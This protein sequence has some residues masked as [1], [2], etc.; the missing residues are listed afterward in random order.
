LAACPG[1]WLNASSADWFEEYARLCF[2]EFGEEVKFWITFNEPKETSI[3][4][5]KIS[6]RGR[7]YMITS[8]RIYRSGT[9]RL[10][11]ISQKT[12]NPR[13]FVGGH[14]CQVSKNNLRKAEDDRRKKINCGFEDFSMLCK[15]LISNLVYLVI[16]IVFCLFQ[17][18][19]RFVYSYERKN[20]SPRKIILSRKTDF[21]QIWQGFQQTESEQSR[22]NRLL[23]FRYN[24]YM[25]TCDRII[26]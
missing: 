2:T 25:R 5:K 23:G 17:S 20:V 19:Y 11:H 14:I 21:Y 3:Q 13:K 22:R 10:C 6:V 1:G 9:H 18:I 7:M 12:N 8:H 16:A 24:E 26:E 15:P 4:G